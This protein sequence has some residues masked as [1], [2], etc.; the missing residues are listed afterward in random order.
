MRSS[1]KTLLIKRTRPYFLI[2]PLLALATLLGEWG[3]RYIDPANLVIV[4]LLL[5]VW[6]SVKWGRGPAVGTS[7]L[8][9][10]AFDFFLIP[11]YLTL[12]VGDTQYL[13]TLAGFLIV[14]LLVSELIIKAREQEKKVKE[15]ELV[16]ESEKLQAALFNSISH[17]LRTPL[18]SI[19]GT[20]SMLLHDSSWLDEETKKELIENAFEQSDRLN[21]LVSNLLDMSR[22]EAGVLKPVLKPCDLTDVL[23]V[24]LEELKEKLKDRVVEVQIPGGFEEVCVDFSLIVKVFVNLIDNAMKYSDEKSIIKI[25]ARVDAFYARVEIMDA[26]CGIPVSDL[27]KVFDKFYRAENSN[28]VRGMGLGL[29]ICR[30]I[31]EA[32][33]GQIWAEKNQ[34]SKG[35]TMVVLLPL[36]V[37]HEK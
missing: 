25:S 10:L 27:K 6:V 20:L 37:N 1:V 16:R 30:G 17:D 9:V 14:G 7:I 5:V 13:F 3:K 24:A 19:T 35:T 26:G 31:I 15:L 32:H 11:P 12:T 4:Y 34:S 21:R 2:I 22:V 8:S 36:K 28:Q 29:S 33:Q 18:V 23:G